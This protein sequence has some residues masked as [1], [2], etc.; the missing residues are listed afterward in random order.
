MG[1]AAVRAAVRRI[2]QPALP[3]SVSVVKPWLVVRSSTAR[4]RLTDP[5]HDHAPPNPV[6][7]RTRPPNALD[8]G[9]DCARAHWIR[10]FIAFQLVRITRIAMLVV[11]V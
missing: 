7:Y 11:S 5:A 9:F 2:D 4:P 8:S 10:G 3:P 6:R 1:T